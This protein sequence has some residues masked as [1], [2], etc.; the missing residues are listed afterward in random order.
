V[1]YSDAKFCGPTLRVGVEF[2]EFTDD[3]YLRHPSFR[4]FADE[5]VTGL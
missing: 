4:R 2:L 5:L 3:G 1:H